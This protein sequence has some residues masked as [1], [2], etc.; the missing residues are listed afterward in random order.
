MKT[1]WPPGKLVYT[2]LYQYP[3]PDV[4][5]FAKTNTGVGRPSLAD[6]SV[7]PGENTLYNLTPIHVKEEET[8]DKT[9]GEMHTIS[10]CDDI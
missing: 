4:K 5:F 1:Y 6:I 2:S 3:K 8:P 9:H 7:G 10:V